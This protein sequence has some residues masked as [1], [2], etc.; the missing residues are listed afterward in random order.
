[1]KVIKKEAWIPT[2][3]LELEKNAMDVVTSGEGN[4]LVVAGPGA[5]KTELL[6]QRACFLLQTNT[7]RFPQRI[8]AISFKRDAA[9]NLKERVFLRAGSEL[10]M[11]FDSLTYDSFAK[12]LVDRFRSAL[13]IEFALPDQYEIA[14]DKYII[15][16]YRS[17][18]E[19]F[20]NTNSETGILNDLTGS[21]LPV[22]GGDRS[23]NLHRFVWGKAVSQG[24]VTF[25][26]VMRLSEYILNTNPKIKANLQKTYAYI[27]LDEFQDTTSIQYDFLKTCFYGSDKVLTAVGDDKQRI[28][29][30]AGARKTVFEDFQ[31]D[32]KAKRVPLTMNFRSAPLLVKVQNSLIKSL[33]NKT[34]FATPSSKWKGGEGECMV[35]EF[36]DQT[37]EAAHLVKSISHWLKKEKL[38]PR[39][40]CIL[41]KGSLAKYVTQLID[42]L[43]A[44][45]IN[46]RDESVFQEFLTDEVI[47]Y[48]I[49]LWYLIID[50]PKADS[51]A[52]VFSF[53][54]RVSNELTDQQLLKLEN[55]LS[56]FIKQQKAEYFG[57]KFNK[58]LVSK[59]V[60]T[61]IAYASADRIRS[62]IPQ[63][64]Q[65][66][67]LTKMLSDFE[68]IVLLYLE[69]AKSAKGALDQ[70]CGLD[71]IPV[72]TVHKSKG[73]EYHTIVF[74]G[75][76]DGAFWTFNTQQDE[77][78]STFFV[79]LSRAK[80][81]VVFT[82]SKTRDGTYKKN[83][84]REN[85]KVIFDELAKA[86]VRIEQH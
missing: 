18:S 42:S 78:K 4:N 63:Y 70:F 15:D 41:V 51:K 2:D 64:R 52:I 55:R 29:A 19:E 3:G 49:H 84:S 47:L 35:W 40:I 82:F 73:L 16:L 69:S 36:N 62:I 17:K 83:Q 28:M 57:K 46:A 76:E 71:T 68:K 6:A 20:V 65:T 48:L 8:L 53:L 9:Y 43:R 79:A 37:T 10:S 11:R 85:I 50:A 66:A 81:R 59:L 58:E 54:S 23:A 74:V 31:T 27:F 45:D 12:Q 86:G 26:M 21:M 60:Q 25:R 7:C 39:D 61:M 67:Y 33:L 13:P 80:L 5:G 22:V 30:W 24:R 75:L 72:M 32:S 1:M 44:T 56:F 77:D 34:D 14:G 38:D